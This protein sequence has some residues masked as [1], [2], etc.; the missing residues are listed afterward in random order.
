MF[1]DGHADLK[2]LR[3]LEFKDEDGMSVIDRVNKCNEVC[4]FSHWV[5]NYI[6]TLDDGTVE[7][8]TYTDIV[9][10]LTSKAIPKIMP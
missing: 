10:L 6:I 9:N 4:K 8:D 7:V 2:V 3:L 5:L 1:G